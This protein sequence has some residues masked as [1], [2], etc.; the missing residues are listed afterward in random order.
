MQRRFVVSRFR[1]IPLIVEL[2]HPLQVVL[3]CHIA[4]IRNPTKSLKYL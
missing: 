3:T 4:H 1:A 2:S